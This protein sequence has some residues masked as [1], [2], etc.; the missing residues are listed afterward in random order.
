MIR[1]V[2]PATATLYKTAVIDTPY[3]HHPDRAMYDRDCGTQTEQQCG[4]WGDGSDFYRSS[5]VKSIDECIATCEKDNKCLSSEFKPSNGKCWLYSKP[6]SEAKTRDDKTGT[7]IFN[8]EN[9]QP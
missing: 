1:E 9:C 7:W 5:T 8:D 3:N 6:V 2:R 4:V